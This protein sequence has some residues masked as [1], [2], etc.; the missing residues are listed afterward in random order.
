MSFFVKSRDHTVS[1][2]SAMKVS[3]KNQATIGQGSIAGCQLTHAALRCVKSQNAA[4]KEN[5]NIKGKKRHWR[6]FNI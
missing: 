5:K 2:Q 1:I 3:I 6:T 4:V